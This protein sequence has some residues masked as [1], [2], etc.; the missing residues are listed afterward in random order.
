MQVFFQ[1]PILLKVCIMQLKMEQILSI[2][3]LG[4]QILRLSGMHCLLP[5]V[6]LCLLQ[7]QEI[8]VRQMNIHVLVLHPL[9][10]QLITG[11]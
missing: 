10:R 6:I 9:I 11:F 1:Q 8:V 3:L 2:C 7:L 5:L 4:D